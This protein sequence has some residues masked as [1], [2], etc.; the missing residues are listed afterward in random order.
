MTDH[1]AASI[2]SENSFVLDSTA[3]RLILKKFK[4]QYCFVAENY[5]VA[6]NSAMG[7]DAPFEEVKLPDGT[8]MKL[9]NSR[10]SGPEIMFQPSL[11]GKDIP[12]VQELVQNAIKKADIDLRT[13]LYQNITLSGG[14]TMIKNF[15]DRLQAELEKTVSEGVK[16]KIIAPPERRFSVWIG[17]SVLATLATFQSSWITK[18]EYDDTGASIVHRKCL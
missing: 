8:P 4:E 5:T 9:K 13:G 2:R 14:N 3:D 11:C 6:L 1:F 7:P 18:G 12:S 17:G 10:F 16:I 15:N